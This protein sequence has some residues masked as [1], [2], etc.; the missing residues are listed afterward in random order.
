MHFENAKMYYD[1]GVGFL[2]EK[3]YQKAI[4]CFD[5]ALGID[6]GYG[7]ARTRKGFALYRS[8]R[9]NEALEVFNKAIRIYPYCLIKYFQG[10]IISS[11]SI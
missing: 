1:K 3:K 7:N 6:P 9:Y 8:G 2:N 4:E 10:L 11:R 5:S